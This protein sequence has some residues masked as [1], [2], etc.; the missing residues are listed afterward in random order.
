ME[1]WPYLLM[2]WAL[3]ALMIWLTIDALRTQSYWVKG[4]TLDWPWYFKVH[5]DTGA[6]SYWFAVITTGL[7]GAFC[8][9]APLFVAHK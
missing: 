7:V 6:F 1:K 2:S 3:G 8:F 4:K 9:L 5:K